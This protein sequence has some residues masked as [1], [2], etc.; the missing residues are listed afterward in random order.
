MPAVNATTPSMDVRRGRVKVILKLILKKL[1]ER[2][3]TMGL[4]VSEVLAL[5]DFERR[6]GSR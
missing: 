6:G 5:I 4:G 3:I 2:Q 1:R